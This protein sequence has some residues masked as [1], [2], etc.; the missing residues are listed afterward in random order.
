MKHKEQH[1]LYIAVDN[2]WQ[3]G[4]TQCVNPSTT[5]AFPNLMFLHNLPASAG[6]RVVRDPLKDDTLG[7]IEQGAVGEVGVTCDPA[8]VGCAPVHISRL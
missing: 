4:V 1:E 3:A 2:L 7:P 6:V 5:F 8:T